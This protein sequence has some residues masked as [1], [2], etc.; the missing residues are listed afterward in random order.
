M[1]E[2]TELGDNEKLIAKITTNMGGIEIELYA[3]KVPK[4]VENFVGLSLQGYYDGIIFHRVIDN[5]MI[6]GGDPTGS[7]SGGKS[8][9]GEYF[10][11]ISLAL[12]SQNVTFTVFIILLITTAISLPLCS[13]S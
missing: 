8:Y 1:E 4:T 7:G 2:F 9:F 6:Q 10:E 12:A 3:D 5:F 13:P 11:V